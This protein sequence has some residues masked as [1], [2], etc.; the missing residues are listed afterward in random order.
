M[1]I[2]LSNVV[3]RLVLLETKHPE[4]RRAF[5]CS[6]SD[7]C[8]LAVERSSSAI[9]GERERVQV[10]APL[11]WRGEELP[12]GCARVSQ[13]E[14]WCFNSGAPSRVRPRW[15]AA[16]HPARPLF[17]ALHGRELGPLVPSRPARLE[18]Q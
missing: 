18:Q 3:A 8:K 16:T 12:R 13:P 6:M 17:S 5:L 15:G 10:D 1:R 11:A 7:A 14:T 4:E 2:I 9:G